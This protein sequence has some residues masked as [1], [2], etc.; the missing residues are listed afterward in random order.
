MISP[1]SL[2]LNRTD[3]CILGR[4]SSSGGGIQHA[5]NALNTSRMVLSLWPVSDLASWTP[6]PG[7]A[8]TLLDLASD[9][10]LTMVNLRSSPI[11]YWISGMQGPRWNTL[12]TVGV[13]GCRLRTLHTPSQ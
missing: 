9:A 12:H 5:R 10:A 8:T 4:A 11:G 13:H 6:E 2:K 7:V 1:L 3:I